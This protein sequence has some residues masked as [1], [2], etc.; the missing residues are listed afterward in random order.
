MA[1]ICP[2]GALDQGRLVVGASSAELGLRKGDP[3]GN[4]RA[5]A[6][7]RVSSGAQAGCV[8][9][10]ERTLVCV[11]DGVAVA[12][13]D[14]EGNVLDRQVVRAADEWRAA[15]PERALPLWR[16]IGRHTQPGR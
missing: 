4:L 13:L 14:V 10:E 16:V 5:P 3:L 2:G 12:V 1:W 8:S 11:D 15:F 9:L 6:A 7:I